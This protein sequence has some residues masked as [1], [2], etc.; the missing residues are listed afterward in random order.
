M[1]SQSRNWIEIKAAMRSLT[2]NPRAQGVIWRHKTESLWLQ[3]FSLVPRMTPSATKA[4]RHCTLQSCSTYPSNLE[5]GLIPSVIPAWA[6]NLKCCQKLLIK[7]NYTLA[8]D[9][10]D[11]CLLI[12]SCKYH[13]PL[14]GK[15]KK[16]HQHLLECCSPYGDEVPWT[17]SALTTSEADDIFQVFTC[18]EYPAKLGQKHMEI[19]SN[20]VG[21]VL[22]TVQLVSQNRLGLDRRSVILRR[23]LW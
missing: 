12:L 18:L 4:L 20:S 13:N 3:T 22:W 23:Q 10:Q 14:K 8:L 16:E 11:L 17:A 7:E 21:S 15:K 1:K 6:A 5:E 9:K 19:N 2:T